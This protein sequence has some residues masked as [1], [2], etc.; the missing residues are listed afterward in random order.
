MSRI[1]KKPIPLPQ[2]VSADINGNEVLVKGAKGELKRTL[3]PDMVIAKKDGQ[4]VVTRPSDSKLH[5]SLHG[6]TRTL[7]A[8]MVEGVSKGFEKSLDI[9]GVGYR[10]QK[11]GDKITLQVGFTHPKVFAPPSGISLA[12]E[13]TNKIKVQ[14]IDKELVGL[15]AAHI[16]E[17]HPPDAYKGKGI[18]YS[19]ERIRLKAGKAGKATAKKK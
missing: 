18:K 3:H 16:R 7:V 5:K 14:G 10:A 13:G 11:T 15:V 19:E 4:L 1:G 9:S 17:I 2:G 12:V 8:N 6:L